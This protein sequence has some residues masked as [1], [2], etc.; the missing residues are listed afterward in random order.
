MVVHLFGATSS[1]SCAG[2][3][4]RRT[5]E[6]NKSSFSAEAV[7][8]VLSNFYVDD[9]LKSVDTEDHAVHLYQELK[10][11]CA[12]GGFNLTKWTSNSRVVL[13]SIPEAERAKE[14]KDLDLDIED[15][16]VERALGVRWCAEVDVFKFHVSLRDQPCT[17]RGI[18]SK[19]SS[20]YDPLGFLAPLTFPP[21]H[22]LQELCRLNLGW[23]E[24]IP[25]L[26]SQAWKR[27]L[28]G[29]QSLGD[30]NITH[31][32]KP[33]NFGNIKGAQLH[34][35]SDASESGYGAVTYLRLTNSCNQ[36]HV[37]FVM[38]KSRV[39][40]L[41]LLTTPCLELTAAVLAVHI[42]RMLFTE[43]QLS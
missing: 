19:V 13:A 14:V 12:V 34:H 5:A 29:L 31:C 16:P 41:K 18:L 11:L 28:N 25:H 37:A 3:A 7:S 8:T 32:F 9:L 6:D 43:L 36:T 26:Y 38:G 10:A 20:I 23:D 24:Q 21:K 17:R 22:I 39:A 40:P 4:L 1:S 27:W 33:N 30:F 42:N 15:L 35:R 2:Y